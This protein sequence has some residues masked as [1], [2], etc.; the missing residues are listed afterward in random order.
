[1]LLAP[2]N[3]I[4]IVLCNAKQT[5]IAYKNELFA[6]PCDGNIQFAIDKLSV[7]FYG[8]RQYLQ[9]TL[10]SH[11]RR[12][13]DYVALAALKTFYSVDGDIFG[14]R[15]I[16]IPHLLAYGRNLSAKRNDDTKRHNRVP[17]DIV[18]HLQFVEALH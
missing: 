10:R 12:E 2:Q 5:E 11:Y 13:E 1:M 3:E 18:R 7:G 15:D 6:C 14:T 4:A 17:F 9:Q 8:S 16:Q